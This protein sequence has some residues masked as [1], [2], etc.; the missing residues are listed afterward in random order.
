MRFDPVKIRLAGASELLIEW[1]DS[2]ISRI[3]LEVLRKKC[4]CATCIA[5][6]TKQSAKYIPLFLR[7]QVT[8]KEI[9]PV[10]SYALNVVWQDGHSTGI[11]EYNTLRSMNPE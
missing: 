6:K 5:E 1:N 3:P 11:Y 8:V 4:P 10:G 2:K 9:K 7:D